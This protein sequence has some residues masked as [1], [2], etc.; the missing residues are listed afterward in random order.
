M[1]GRIA[2]KVSSY[3]IRTFDEDEWLYALE[4][5]F[6]VEVA[7]QMYLLISGDSILMPRRVPH[8]WAYTGN[9]P[10]RLLINRGSSL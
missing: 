8:V 7:T 2:F 5:E 1:R 6:H 9:S 10:G 4:G 3:D